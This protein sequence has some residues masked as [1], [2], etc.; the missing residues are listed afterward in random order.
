MKVG[1]ISSLL[2]GLL[3][4]PAGLVLIILGSMK[5]SDGFIVGGTGFL[6]AGVAA[7]AAIIFFLLRWWKCK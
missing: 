6:L 7:I 5:D 4:L 3:S 2:L 1:T